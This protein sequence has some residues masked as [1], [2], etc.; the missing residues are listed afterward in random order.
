MTEDSICK[1]VCLSD[2]QTE[3]HQEQ[4]E[5]G[6][7]SLEK[8]SLK[9]S[10]CAMFYFIMLFHYFSVSKIHQ[11]SGTILHQLHNV[12]CFLIHK[13]ICIFWNLFLSNIYITLVISSVKHLL[14]YKHCNKHIISFNPQTDPYKS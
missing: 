9:I 11:W 12:G 14:Y 5:G 3:N 2:L 4:R 13:F 10:H 6:Y 1:W 7:L 8:F